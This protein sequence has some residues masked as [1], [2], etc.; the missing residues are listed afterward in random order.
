MI[1]K[2][3]QFIKENKNKVNEEYRLNYHF[4]APIG[5]IN[6]PNGFSNYKGEY[7]LFYQ[8]H[9]YDPT[10]GPMHWGHAKTKDFITWEHQPI[11]LAPDENYDN[12][13]CFSGTALVHEDKLWVM[14]TGVN[15][16][17][18]KE[19]QEQCIAFSEDGIHFTKIKENPVIS[20]EMLPENIYKG[21]FRDPKIYQVG[22]E[23]YSASV[24]KDKTKGGK[25]YLYKSKDLKNWTFAADMIPQL[26]NFG[27]MWECPD[28]FK[29]GSKDVVLMSI[30]EL[31]KEENLYWNKQSSLYFIGDIDAT[32]NQL[33]LDTYSEIDLGFDFYAPQTVLTD[34]GRR[35]MIAWMQA[36]EETIPV[37]QLGH[38][39]AGAMTL[40]REIVIKDGKIYQRPVKEMEAHRTSACTYEKVEVSKEKPVTLQ[41]VCGKSIEVQLD[42]NVKEAKTF[43]M[44]LFKTEDEKATLTYDVETEMLTFDRSLV[45]HPIQCNHFEKPNYREQKISLEDGHLKLHVFIDTCS[46]E[47]FIQE[48]EYTITSMV[49]PIGKDYGIEFMASGTTIIEKLEKWDILSV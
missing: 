4:M 48:G 32:T 37:Q 38:H 36:W 31:E 16:E 43:T 35:V 22:D 2:A 44:N 25:L 14:Y 40:P 19:I 45:G 18:G 27:I 47:I 1:N 9:P 10:W 46:V 34:D 41:D 17:K 20:K 24:V 12:Q 7:H 23:F 28:I 49:Y 3:N 11:A 30:I 21:D 33:Q 29:L 26:E 13:G 39:W 8:H 15:G 6:D 5:W 42:V